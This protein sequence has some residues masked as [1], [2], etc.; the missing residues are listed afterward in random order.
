MSNVNPARAHRQRVLAAMRG[1]KDE[2]PDARAETQYELM[3]LQLAEHRR[4]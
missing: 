3:L 1:E 2:V 4:R